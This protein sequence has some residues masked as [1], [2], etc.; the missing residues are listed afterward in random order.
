MVGG[1]RVLYPA[2]WCV[3]PFCTGAAGNSFC[4]LGD[5]VLRQFDRTIWVDGWGRAFCRGPYDEGD[6]EEMAVQRSPDGYATVN[7]S[8]SSNFVGLPYT[9]TMRLATLQWAGVMGPSFI[10]SETCDHLVG[11][12]G[13]STLLSLSP[14]TSPY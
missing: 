4:H 1:T 6:L 7:V 11:V 9:S 13:A 3:A 2:D 14:L 8:F 12:S 10:L 5:L